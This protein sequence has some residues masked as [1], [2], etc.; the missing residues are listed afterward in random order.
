MEK[1]MKKTNNAEYMI[2]IIQQHAAWHL[3]GDLNE[4]EKSLR[5]YPKCTYLLRKGE[6]NLHYFV[7]YISLE[8]IIFH[9]SI[10]INPEKGGFYINGGS[11]CN[12]NQLFQSVEQLICKL[13]GCKESDLSPLSNSM[14]QVQGF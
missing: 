8:S 6:D 11:G 1:L 12:P 4:A 10:R 7:S 2:Q 3:T 9:K 5:S 14:N 13:I